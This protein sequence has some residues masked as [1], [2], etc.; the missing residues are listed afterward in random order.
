[1]QI[2]T[3]KTKRRAPKPENG[4]K[5]PFCDLL[6]CGDCHSKLHYHTNT[7]NRDIHYFSCGNYTK[8]TRGTCQTRHYIRADAIEQVVKLELSQL[9]DLLR[10]DEATFAELLAQK[11]M[12]EAKAEQKLM[13]DE[14]QK[15]LTRN[16]TVARM[17]EKLYEDNVTGKVSDEWFMQLSHKYEVE[18]MEL[19]A[20]IA[21]LRKKLADTGCRQQ[22][23]QNFLNAIRSFMQMER[24]TAPIL[25]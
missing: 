24:L 1:M 20:K 8:D 23:Q 18:R 4:E 13:E 19:K 3:A 14:L 6:Y 10:E 22:G 5:S 21:E 9:V 16:E 11:T 7:I 15:A 12:K 2:L 17:Y 25:R